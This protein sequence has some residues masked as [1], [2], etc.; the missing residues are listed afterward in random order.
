VV[1]DHRPI[2]SLDLASLHLPIRNELLAVITKVLDSGKYVLG[3]EVE[4]LEQEIAAYVG[5]SHAI[6]CASGSDALTL[7][8]WARQIQP[9]DEVLTTPFSFF[10]TAGSVSRAGARPVFVDIDP[11]TFNMDMNRL[12]DALRR[13]PRVRAIIPVH[14]FGGCADM[15]PLKTLAAKHGLSVIEDAAQA[16]GA[17]YK[18]KRAGSLGDV[19]CFSFYPTKNLGGLGEGG[20]LTTRDAGLA[21]RL[22]ALRIHG[23]TGPYLYEWIGINSKLDALQAAALRVK[24]KYLDGWTERRQQNAASYRE[25]L[26]GVPVL[27]PVA[28]PYQTRHIY[29]Q[30][31]IRGMD[32]GGLREFLKERGVGAEVYYP[33]PLHLQRCFADLGYHKGDFPA[34]EKAASE[35]LA[36]PVNPE[37]NFDDVEY[38][39]QSIA[40]FYRRSVAR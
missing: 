9:G 31:V 2:P 34:S 39:C 22:K 37:V 26:S 20:M 7:A 17:E 10:A 11:S 13:R 25:M 33:V 28:A 29:N 5:T 23:Q 27:A 4:R 16:I 18:G 21:A 30:F 35:V 8:L 14:L 40:S 6:G 1:I 19:G 3:E 32:R 38:V 36:L 24:L 12:E 15:D